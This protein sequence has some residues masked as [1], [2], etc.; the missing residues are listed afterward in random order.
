VTVLL[1]ESVVS[2]GDASFDTVLGFESAVGSL[3]SDTLRAT[4]LTNMLDGGAGSH[5]LI[6]LSGNHTLG[7]GSGAYKIDGGDGID[8]VDYGSSSV[9]VF[10]TLFHMPGQ[11]GDAEGDT[12]TGVENIIGS[13]YADT[14]DGDNSAKRLEGGDGA[15]MLLGNGSKRCCC[16]IEEITTHANRVARSLHL[17]ARKS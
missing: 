2:G 10:A 9:G 12:I 3:F 4:D 1:S 7:V 6:G 14:V 15:D 17:P 16:I 5:T 8:T 13:R 11:V